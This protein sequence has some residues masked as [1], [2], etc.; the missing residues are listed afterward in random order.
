[1]GNIFFL[2]LGDL[3]CPGQLCTATQGGLP[4]YRDEDHLTGQFAQTLAPALRT[5]LFQILRNARPAPKR[6]GRGDF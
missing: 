3:I 4:V 2:D 5:R 1:M 6:D